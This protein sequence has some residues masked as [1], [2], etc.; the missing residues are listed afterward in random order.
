M[1][2]SIA[3]ALFTLG[4]FAWAQQR[5]EVRHSKTNA[6][7]VGAEIVCQKKI[8]GKT[9]NKGVLTLQEKCR[10]IEVSAPGFYLE[11]AEVNKKT[12]VYLTPE[13]PDINHISAVTITDK[14][15][16][17]ALAILKKVNENYKN[18]SPNSLPSYTFKSYDKITFDL[19]QDS[20]KTYTDFNNHRLDSLKQLPEFYTKPKKVKD[21]LEAVY[22]SKL[23]G[24][25]KLFL[26]ERVSEYLHSQ[27]YGQ[28]INIL[29][30]RMAGLNQPVYEFLALRSNRT[31]MPKEILEEN[32]SLYRFF[33]TDSIEI[34]NRPT[35]VIR[36]REVNKKSQPHRRKFNGYIYID[37]A[38]YGIKKIESDSKK[39]GEGFITSVWTL[40]QDKWFLEKEDMKMRA[41][42]FVFKDVKAEEENKKKKKEKSNEEPKKEK[43]K[44]GNY[45]YMTS[46]YFGFQSP[47][48]EDPK[49]F[50]GYSLDVVNSD[51]SLLNQYRQEPLTEREINTYTKIDSVGKK[52]KLDQKV[53]IA[54]ALFNGKLRYGIFDFDITKV[55]EYNNYERLRLGAAIKLNERFNKYIS[56]DVYFAYGFGDHTWKY[57][58]GVDIK[59]SLERH[60][61]FRVEYADDVMASGRFNEVLWSTR[62]RIMNSGVN[63]NNRKY[64]HY[65][66]F[67]LAYETDLGRSFVVKVSAKRMNERVKFE[68]DF[69]DMGKDFNNTSTQITLRYSP[70]SKSMMTPSGKY[71]FE[72]T[73]PEVFVNYEKSYKALGGDFTFSKVDALVMHQHQSKLGL[74]NMMVYGGLVSG[75]APIWHQFAMNGLSNGKE[76]LNYNITSF[77]GFA[78]LEGGRYFND[79]F[80]GGMISHRIPW[81]FKSFGKNVSSLDVVYKGVIGNMKHP[82]IY[83]PEFEKL[84]K[85]YQEVGL[86]Y[87]NFLSTPF[88]L[89]FFYR[90]GHYHTS[91]FKDNFAIQLKFKLLGF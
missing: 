24:E 49:K 76:G 31:R 34:D 73:Y 7:V 35:Y 57:G 53:N 39:I 9:N 65:N 11:D 28:K 79:R 62:M 16:P 80:V 6:P 40:Y 46:R 26:W 64:Y 51:G 32:R 84:N 52:Y 71:M 29:D 17:K 81:Y 5:I 67:K 77:L 66:G 25:S 20:I 83:Q 89:G 60:S 68:H 74:T 41:G 91:N 30:N 2:K 70:N 50:K 87:N 19:D 8:V 59:T 47:I 23:I 61:F 48:E 4:N 3:I 90:V 44:F 10:S 45:I 36:F 85:L 88:N 37:Q 38:T 42:S 12:I 69:A 54:R 56:P 13:D 1:K 33:L 14:S 86:E 21:S 43:I 78:T 15:D 58:L 72:H 27:N 22:F 63:F 18:N 82:E 55:I 75:T